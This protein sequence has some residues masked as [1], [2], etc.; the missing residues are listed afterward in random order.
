MCALAYLGNRFQR[1]TSE[2]TP[3]EAIKIKKLFYLNI[4]TMTCQHLSYIMIFVFDGIMQEV[5]KNKG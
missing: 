5:Y 1:N 3:R 2:Q 4:F